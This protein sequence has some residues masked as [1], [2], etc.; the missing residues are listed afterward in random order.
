LSVPGCGRHVSSLLTTLRMLLQ[1]AH[2]SGAEL[3][4]TYEQAFARMI[5]GEGVSAIAFPRGRVALWAI[6]K[7]LDIHGESEVV[8][9]AYTCETV[10]MAVKFAG[11][12]C[13]YTDVEEG[14]YNSSARDIA[15]AVTDRTRAIICQHT[16]G[17]VQEVRDWTPLVAGTQ[18]ILIE[19]R[20]QLI[21]NGCAGDGRFPQS[22]AAYFST[23]FNKPFSTTQGGMAVFSDSTLCSEVRRICLQFP[24][25][26]DRKRTRS[27]A[28]QT[29]LYTVTVRPATRALMGCLYRWA[30]RA[31]L[32]R[33]TISVEEYGGTM[34]AD[35]LSHATNFQAVLGMAELQRW[36]DNC[37]H[38]KQLTAFYLERLEML[39]MDIS[40]LTV[41]SDP[42]VLLMVPLLV[43]NK[44]ELLTQAMRNGLP[45]GTWFDRS[46]AHMQ[47]RSARLYDYTPGQCPHAEYQMSHEIHLPT[48]PW[49]SQRQAD[50]AIG[51]IERYA[52][53]A[54]PLG[55]ARLAAPRGSGVA[56]HE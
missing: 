47:E 52:Q 26:Y 35:Y 6:L 48:A 28:V 43:R 21:Q 9:P 42:P 32:I 33:G 53:L 30:Q 17:I 54:D 20:C 46:P 45:I 55:G 5:V 1:P 18:A 56:V 29:L 27:L 50:R 23:H 40:A 15:Q 25:T 34:P 8:L 51:F 37:R 24:S 38:R 12:K 10:P 11:A 13:I 41:G 31:G 2:A 14:S 7:A 22:I 49:V 16:Y 36:K 19:D 39:G 3:V 44:R 4:P